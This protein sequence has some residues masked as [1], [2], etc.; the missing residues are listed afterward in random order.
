MPLRLLRAISEKYQLKVNANEKI[1]DLNVGLRQKV[2]ILKSLV[3]ECKILILDEP[4]AVLT[5][6]GDRGAVCT[7]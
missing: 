6:A 2:E 3:R 4:T 1:A 7:A 5:P